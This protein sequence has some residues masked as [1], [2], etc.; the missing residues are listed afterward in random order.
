MKQINYRDA[1]WLTLPDS[2]EVEDDLGVQAAFFERRPH[3]GTLRVSVFGFIM[4]GGGPDEPMPAPVEGPFLALHQG[5]RMYTQS[6]LAPGRSHLL[7]RNWIFQVPEG[8]GRYLLVF[9]SHTIEE[10]HKDDPEA[11]AEFQ[12]VDLAVRD[13]RISLAPS[14]AR[15]DDFSAKGSELE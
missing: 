1:V 13:A 8:P 4:D 7:M 14:V 6:R 12:V 2:F 15:Y 10:A 3:A 5:A 9:F 11:I